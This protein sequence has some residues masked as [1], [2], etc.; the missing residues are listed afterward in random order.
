MGVPKL[1]T[2]LNNPKGKDEIQK[3]IDHAH[4]VKFLLT[5]SFYMKRSS[6]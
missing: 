2:F 4:N 3:L 5:F 6:N 1:K